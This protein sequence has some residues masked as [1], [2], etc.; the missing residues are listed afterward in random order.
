MALIQINLDNL[1]PH[2]V[3]SEKIFQ[4]LER[5]S[6]DMAEDKSHFFHLPEKSTWQKECSNTDD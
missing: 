3:S 5:F 4:D 2:H 6:K 1:A